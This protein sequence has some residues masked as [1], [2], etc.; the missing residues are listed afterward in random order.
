MTLAQSE[1][2][3]LYR[4]APDAQAIFCRRRHQPSRPTRVLPFVQ[5]WPCPRALSWLARAFSPSASASVC[6]PVARSRSAR[7]WRARF[8]FGCSGPSAFPKI[9]STRSWSCRAP[10]KSPFCLSRMAKARSGSGM[11]GAKHL[12]ADRQRALGE[13]LR[14]R[15]L[16][17]GVQQVGEVIEDQW[18][19]GMLRT[20]CPLANRKRA[21]VERPRS[22]NIALRGERVGEVVKP[23]CLLRY[24]PSGPE[25]YRR[26]SCECSPYRDARGRAPM[27]ALVK[28]TL[29]SVVLVACAPGSVVAL[30]ACVYPAIRDGWPTGDSNPPRPGDPGKVAILCSR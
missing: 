26:G 25:V 19:I 1:P 17:L 13:R 14:L 23:R 11:L 20:E 10:A 2:K 21:L 8:V 5:E 4:I 27:T 12:F 29:F 22:L 24:V 9:A 28:I 3:I 7:L 6:A 15:K 16:A 30:P 18:R